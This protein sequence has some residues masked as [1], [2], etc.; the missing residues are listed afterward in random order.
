VH[1]EIKQNCKKASV[2]GVEPGPLADQ[3]A[4]QNYR[5]DLA[6]GSIRGMNGYGMTASG[7]QSGPSANPPRQLSATTA[8]MRC[9]NGAATS[10]QS[11]VAAMPQ[12]NANR[13][14]PAT[15]ESGLDTVIRENSD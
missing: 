13:L 15:T 4:P 7:A 3:A 2:S 14:A 11:P 5:G 8:L 1:R 6:Q 12:R 9:S 10:L